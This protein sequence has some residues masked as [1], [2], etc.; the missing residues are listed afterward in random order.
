MIE[1]EKVYVERDEFENFKHEVDKKF[2]RVEDEIHIL[3][4]NIDIMVNTTKAYMEK[5]DKYIDFIQEL[6]KKQVEGQRRLLDEQLNAQR[7]NYR[8]IL[9]WVLSI[10]GTGGVLG[11]IIYIII[12]QI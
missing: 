1:A 10:L 9:G 5:H 6:L 3:S 2:E 11:I 8:K 4:N 7:Q 12:H